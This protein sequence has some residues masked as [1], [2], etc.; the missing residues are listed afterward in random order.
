MG[1]NTGFSWQTLKESGQL[2]DLGK[3]GAQVQNLDLNEKH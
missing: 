3:N 2:E 1:D